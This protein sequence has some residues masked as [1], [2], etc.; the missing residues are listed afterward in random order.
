MR[1]GL[2]YCTYHGD[3]VELLEIEF[4]LFDGRECAGELGV[5]L[6]AV[7]SFVVEPC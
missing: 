5:S 6:E 4:L 2:Q 7:L 3:K 1:N